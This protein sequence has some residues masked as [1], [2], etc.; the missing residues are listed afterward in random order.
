MPPGAIFL[1]PARL[2]ECNPRHKQIK[3][4][5]HVDLFPSWDKGIE[6][7]ARALKISQHAIEE[8]EPERQRI[9]RDLD[10]LSAKDYF[11]I[12]LPVMLRWKGDDATSLNK[13]LRFVLMDQVDESWTLNLIPPVATVVAKDNSKVD[14]TLK[15]TTK[16]MQ[17]ILAGNFDA[18]KAIA[19]GDVE[20]YGDLSLLNAVGSLF[21][22]AKS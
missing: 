9:T 15:I 4:L 10:A 21:S 11:D 16:C 6:G 12:V 5:H 20:I 13:K 14:M 2:E 22:S 7:I 17:D 19:D 18:K 1:I 3:K 8:S